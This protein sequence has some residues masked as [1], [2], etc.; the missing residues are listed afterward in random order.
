MICLIR[1]N[2]KKIFKRWTLTNFESNYLLY[3]QK[4]KIKRQAVISP[5]NL[6]LKKIIQMNN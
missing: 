5:M 1:A 2:P 3:I 4:P 6:F